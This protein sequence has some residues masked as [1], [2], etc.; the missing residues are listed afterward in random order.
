M[1]DPAP[2][3]HTELLFLFDSQ[4]HWIDRGEGFQ[5]ITPNIIEKG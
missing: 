1:S 5:Y 3:T 2:F 4:N